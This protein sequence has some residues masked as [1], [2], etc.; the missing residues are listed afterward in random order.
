MKKTHL[1]I[2]FFA[3]LI[4]LAGAKTA[5]AT[6]NNFP[7]INLTSSDLTLYIFSTETQNEHDAT[8]KRFKVWKKT[9]NTYAPY[10][11]SDPE[12]DALLGFEVSGSDPNLTLLFNT[13]CDVLLVN[14]SFYVFRGTLTIGV[15]NNGEITGI[16]DVS[17]PTDVTIRRYRASSGS[18]YGTPNLTTNASAAVDGNP[19]ILICGIL[20]VNGTAERKIIFDGGAKFS[21]D[22]ARNGLANNSTDDIVKNCCLLYTTGEILMQHATLQNSYTKASTSTN[23]SLI[24]LA[25]P[26]NIRKSVQL[27]DVKLRNGYGGKGS[28]VYFAGNDKHD[29]VMTRVEI[30]QCYAYETNNGGGAIR[31]LGSSQSTLAI[32]SCKLHDNKAL[33]GGGS[34]MWTCMKQLTIGGTSEAY[35]KIYNNESNRGGGL[36]TSATL[37]LDYVKIY[38]NQAVTNDFTSNT[39]GIGGG[40]LIKSYNGGQAEYDGAGFDIT[41]KDHAYIYNNYAQREGG[42]ICVWVDPTP[43]IGLDAS[44]DPVDAYFRFIMEGGYVF[45]NSAVNGSALFIGQ[46]NVT[47]TATDTDVQPTTQLSAYQS[48]DYIF[49]PLYEADGQADV[50]TVNDQTYLTYQPGGAF[51][52]SQRAARPFES[53]I[54]LTSGARQR[55]YIPIWAIGTNDDDATPIRAIA[56]TQSASPANA[57]HD[58]SIPVYDLSGRRVTAPAKGLHIAGRRKLLV[59]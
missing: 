16:P 1:L 8:L 45:G 37:E 44:D 11:A 55:D 25:N 38:G 12:Y 23:G 58:P 41:I 48:G 50:F 2:T 5:V 31:S 4:A 52:R 24:W 40:V 54:T 15:F 19:M 17:N 46:G 6:P 42:G 36:F 35:T 47:F 51:V 34:I 39:Y 57:L 28:A 59:K 53:Y 13:K 9:G 27:T 7:R 14:N 33:A 20:N 43:D 29:A 10:E 32:T 22:D 3:T 21:G 56:D 18:T 26:G 49:S 30:E